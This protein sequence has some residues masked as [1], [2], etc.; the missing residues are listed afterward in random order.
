MPLGDSNTDSGACEADIKK[1]SL[2]LGFGFQATLGM[3]S[4]SAGQHQL[5]ANG[6]RGR[7]C[8]DGEMLGRSV[9][10]PVNRNKN[11]KRVEA[12]EVGRAQGWSRLKLLHRRLGACE[13]RSLGGTVMVV[14][15]STYILCA[16]RK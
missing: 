2:R 13:I 16:V 7:A 8:E 10:L 3:P 15:Y 14:Q 12:A 4:Q 1:I 6:K 11:K 5:R 9:A